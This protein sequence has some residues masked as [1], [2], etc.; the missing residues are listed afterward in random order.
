MD[1]SSS[2]ISS[3]CAR[4]PGSC[5]QFRKWQKHGPVPSFSSRIPTPTP[6]HLQTKNT[7]KRRRPRRRK[8][9]MKVL[10]FPES[11][12]EAFELG[13]RNIDIRHDP[14]KNKPSTSGSSS[15]SSSVNIPGTNRPRSP[16]PKLLNPVSQDHLKDLSSVPVERDITLKELIESGDVFEVFEV[17]NDCGM[18][19]LGRVEFGENSNYISAT[20]QE[21][22]NEEDAKRQEKEKERRKRRRFRILKM[23]SLK[24]K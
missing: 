3:N 5:P 21:F 16:S 24:R 13:L 18:D 23:F 19:N 17:G 8:A 4:A 9:K 1:G 6:S 2:S 22:C 12:A 10:A 15:T 20:N 11:V 14:N 7:K